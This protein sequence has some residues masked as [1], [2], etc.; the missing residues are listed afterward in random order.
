MGNREQ[1]IADC[2]SIMDGMLTD[3]TELDAKI[4]KANEEIAAVSEQV[5]SCI[6]ENASISLIAG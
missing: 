3:C 2:Q 5:S 4:G 6:R 1:V